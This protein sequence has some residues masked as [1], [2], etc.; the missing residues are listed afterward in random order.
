M[1]LTVL[2][3]MQSI[4]I[5]IADIQFLVIRIFIIPFGYYTTVEIHVS[6]EF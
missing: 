1:I 3:S 5:L 6:T 2:L 4:R